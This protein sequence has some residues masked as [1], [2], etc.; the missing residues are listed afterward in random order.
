LSGRKTIIARYVS[1]GERF[2]ILVD[3]HLAWKFKRGEPVDL[4]DILIS[5]IIYK[6]AKKGLKASEESIRKVFA[7]SNIKTIASIIIKNGTL[8]LTAEHRR[9]L[10]EAKKRKIINFISKNCIDP[11]TNLPHPPKRIELAMEEVGIPIDPFKPAEEQALDIIKA[12]RKIL[13]LKI[14]RITIRV[15][16]PPFCAGKAYGFVSKYGSILKS[17]WLQDGSWLCEVEMPAGL[18]TTFIS[19]VNEISKGSA[20]LEILSLSRRS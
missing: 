11:R 20:E 9:E 18:Q 3:P 6:D 8:Q 19:K 1:M 17:E 7:T 16:F 15:R 14:A 10:I 4:N 13:P 2:E 5:D 12:L